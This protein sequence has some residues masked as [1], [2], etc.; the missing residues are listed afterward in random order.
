MHTRIIPLRR[1]LAAAAAVVAMC[2]GGGAARAD[3]YPDKPIKLVVGFPPGGPTDAVARLMGEK[4]SQALGQP[5]IVENRPGASG[6]IAAAY[7]AKAPADGYT[8]FFSTAG[9]LSMNPFLYKNP[10]F[11]V[12]KD[13][14]PITLAISVPALLVVQPSFPA[15]D[16][17]TLVERAKAAPGSISFASAGFGGP[18]HMAV[19]LLKHVA[20]IDLLHV[21]YKGAGPA[22]TD[23]M[24]GQVQM[25]ILDF[26][27]LLPQV[28][29]GKLKAL[30]I[31]GKTRSPLLPDV[32]TIA[33]AGYPGATF[34][35][36]YGL[37]APSAT[38]ADIRD[39]IGKAFVAALNDKEVH[40]KLTQMGADVV[41]STPQQFDA[42]IR[43]EMK[44]WSDVI[45][46][47]GIKAEQ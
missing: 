33:E 32:P 36:W 45:R 9:V 35:N 47:A 42:Y 26:P 30:A 38:P 39:R 20:S 24:G 15:N 1:A 43:D 46:D 10:G 19:E 41:A 22:M 37:V 5:V 6:N 7:V 4:A 17:K 2:A 8:L 18:P 40:D 21:P 13:F 23:L 14:A 27:V 34:E 44:R 25:S 28:K 29:A 11:D 3:G 16:V 12:L 31:T